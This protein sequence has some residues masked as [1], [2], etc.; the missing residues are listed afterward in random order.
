[1]LKEIVYSEDIRRRMQSGD[2]KTG[3]AIILKALVEPARQIPE[4]S[5]KEGSSVIADVKRRPASVGFNAVTKGQ[6]LM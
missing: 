1:M 3:A 2:M 5:G 6:R 4:N